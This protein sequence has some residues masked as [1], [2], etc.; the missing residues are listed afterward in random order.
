MNICSW[1][2]APSRS[3]A[4]LL[5]DRGVSRPI[6]KIPTGAD[7]SFF[8]AGNEK[9]FRRDGHLPEDALVIG[10]VGRLAPEKNLS[11]LAEA[12]SIFLEKTPEAHFLVIGE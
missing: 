10:H 11:Y 9:R 7:V 5:L 6:E 1:V 4:R 3:I 12:V 2:V 8:A